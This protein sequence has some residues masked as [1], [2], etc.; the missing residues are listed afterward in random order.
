[1]HNRSRLLFTILTALIIVGLGWSFLSSGQS[2]TIRTAT[3][4]VTQ[5]DD[6]GAVG[7][8]LRA[9]FS[10]RHPFWPRRFAINGLPNQYQHLGMRVTVGYVIDD[11]VGTGA[12]DTAVSLRSIAPKH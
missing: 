10:F 9:D 12:W 6:N 1:M 3:G 8:G 7:W 4:T 11:V 5:F 2:A